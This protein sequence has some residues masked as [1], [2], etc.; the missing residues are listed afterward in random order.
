MSE[1]FVSKR[2]DV[3]SL[4]K[5]FPEA[6]ITVMENDEQ[7][8]EVLKKAL[9]SGGISEEEADKKV[10]EFVENCIKENNS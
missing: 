6:T 9:M 7:K 2:V 10:K 1:W 4:R 5:N 8:L 3:D